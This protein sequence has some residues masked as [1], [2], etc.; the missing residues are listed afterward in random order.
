L[1]V[2][3]E[4]ELGSVDPV[5]FDAWHAQTVQTLTGA[6]PRLR[7]GWATKIINVYLKTPVYVGGQGRPG[8]IQ[9]IHPP[10]DGGLWLASNGDFRTGPISLK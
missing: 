6:E 8:L 1:A 7:F 10:I 9:T 3:F 2:L 4:N 5:A